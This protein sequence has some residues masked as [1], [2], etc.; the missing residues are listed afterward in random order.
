VHLYSAPLRLGGTAEACR[1]MACDLFHLRVV[2][3]ASE[4]LL[5]GCFL[6]ILQT[7]LLLF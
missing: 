7:L 6:Q 5:T 2:D 4:A 3:G 1:H